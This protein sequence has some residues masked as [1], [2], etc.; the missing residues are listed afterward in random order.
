MRELIYLCTRSSVCGPSFAAS[1]KKFWDEINHANFSHQ[2]VPRIALM[3]ALTLILATL[4]LAL[5][6]AARSASCAACSV[7]AALSPAALRCAQ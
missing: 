7:L 2:K 5:T 3:V 4:A 6:S 1:T